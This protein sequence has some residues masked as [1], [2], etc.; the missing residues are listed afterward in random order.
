MLGLDSDNGGEF[1]NQ[2]L[3]NYCRKEAITFTRA[4]SYKKN[5]SCYVEQK[6]WSVVR[7]LVGYDRYNSHAALECLN[8]VYA[9]LR[10]YVN[11]FQPTMK[12]ISKTRHGAKVHKVYA[13]ARTPYQRLL[14]SGALTPAKR[15]ELL[16]TYRGL[17]PVLLLS[18][19]NGHLEKLWNLAD[20]TIP[21]AR[22]K[23]GTSSV[24]ANFESTTIIR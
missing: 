5:D 7:R 22:E 18:Q 1:I 11:F 21:K 17:N 8:L 4:R 13:T 10:H 24:T 2:H 3:Y 16:A 12:L 20:R 6:N 15:A 9:T 23:V 19:L 14:E